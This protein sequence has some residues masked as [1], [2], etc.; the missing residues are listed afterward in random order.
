MWPWEHVRQVN[1]AVLWRG[2]LPRRV[3]VEA[4]GRP[5]PQKGA[6]ISE[7]MGGHSFCLQRVERTKCVPPSESAMVCAVAILGVSSRSSGS[8]VNRVAQRLLRAKYV[9]PQSPT[10]HSGFSHIWPRSCC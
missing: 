10:S 3:A 5:R 6:P 7:T 1:T 2:L 8:Y 9:S 4:V